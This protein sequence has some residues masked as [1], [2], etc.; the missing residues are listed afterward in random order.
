[1]CTY[2]RTQTTYVRV[3]R[4]VRVSVHARLCM[5][6]RVYVSFLGPRF[7][8]SEVKCLMLQLLRAVDFMHHRWFLH[9]DL[10][11]SNILYDNRCVCARARAR[12]YVC[13]WVGGR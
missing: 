6:A 7:S 1:M 4:C 11:T 13:Y 10:K 2:T 12:M 5:R 9:R 3:C 8:Q